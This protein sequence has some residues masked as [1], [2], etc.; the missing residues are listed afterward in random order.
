MIPTTATPMIAVFF[1]HVVYGVLWKR[2]RTLSKVG[3]F[4]NQYGVA[5]AS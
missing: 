2:K 1:S 3:P 5:V 4:L